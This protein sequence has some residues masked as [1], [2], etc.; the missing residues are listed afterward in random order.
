MEL[1]AD[2]REGESLIENICNEA[3]H[4]ILESKEF[5][6]LLDDAFKSKAGIYAS[7][8]TNEAEPSVEDLRLVQEEEEKVETTYL[9]KPSPQ[10]EEELKEVSGVDDQELFRKRMFM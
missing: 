5:D 10:Y 2:L 4:D 7:A 6:K 9:N 3:M 8:I 1:G